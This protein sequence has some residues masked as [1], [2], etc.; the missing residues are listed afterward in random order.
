METLHYSVEINAPVSKV[1]KAMLE[2]SYEEW[3]KVFN[4]DSHFEGSWDL[5]SKV[6]FI[7]P[8]PE[9]GKSS[10]MV[11][12]IVENTPNEVLAIQYTGIYMEDQEDT[13]SEEALKWIGAIEKY[14]FKEVDGKTQLD[15]SVDMTEEMKDEM[16]SLW[17]TA[18]EKLKE[19][20]ERN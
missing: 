12:K 8:N 5:G 1:W 4:A 9:T 19:I 15:I 14:T 3:V 18:L 16:G 17:P 11:G 20:A 6:L 10:G 7:G 13:T 2:D